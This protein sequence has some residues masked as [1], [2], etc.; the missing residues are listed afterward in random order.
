M[1]K[2]R[3][4]RCTR[5]KPYQ[6]DCIERDNIRARQGY[7]IQVNSEEEALEEMAKLFPEDTGYGF[8]VQPWKGFDDPI[9]EVQR[10][11]RMP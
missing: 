1:M 6:Q 2:P 10:E 5:N 4:Y 11:Q 8:T 9:G 7:Y 3:E